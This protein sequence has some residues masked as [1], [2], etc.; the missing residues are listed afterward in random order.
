MNESLLLWGLALLAASLLLII[1]EV[2]VPSG[3]VI[4]LVAAVVAISGVVCLFRV[5]IVWGLTGLLAMV[6]L[7]PI[8]GMFALK[9]LPSTPMGRRLIHGADSPDADE[10]GD[11]PDE[12]AGGLDSLIGAE[13]VALTDLRMVGVVRVAG[14]KHPGISEISFIRAGTSVRVTA[15]DGNQLRVRPL[16]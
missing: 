5:G 4:S 3:G 9:I 1:V 8:V 10:N 2:F 13:G 16:A 7:A 6:I 12:P 11:A 14:R 15:V